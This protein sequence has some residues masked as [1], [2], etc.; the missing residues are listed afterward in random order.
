M[1]VCLCVFVLNV[2]S[3]LGLWGGGLNTGEQIQNFVQN[4]PKSIGNRSK[5]DEI[6]VSG[7]PG[8]ILGRRLR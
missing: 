8:T 2:Y 7:R 5:M 1:F 3:F 4:Q 6:L